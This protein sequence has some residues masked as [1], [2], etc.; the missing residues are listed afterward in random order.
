MSTRTGGTYEGAMT[1]LRSTEGFRFAIDESGVH[2]EGTMS[3]PTVGAES[4]EFRAN[5]EDWRGSAGPQ[6]VSWERKIGGG[7]SPANPPAFANRLYQRVTLAFD[8]Q[9]KEGEAQ[10]VE[11]DA[12]SNHFR[13]TNANTGE[14]HDVR[15]SRADDRVERI[16]IGSTMKLELTPLGSAPPSP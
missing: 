4:V 11:T 9:K 15:V 14:V 8:P 1:W 10:L 2:A 5:G 12:S 16:T 3:R 13:F 7:W 6:G